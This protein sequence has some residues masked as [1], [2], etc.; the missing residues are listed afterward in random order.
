MNT[1]P[2]V[3]L[4]AGTVFSAGNVRADMAKD[5]PVTFLAQGALPAKHPP[6]RSSKT[7]QATEKDYYIF[8][9]PERSRE[10]IE[11]IRAEMPKGRF[12]APPNDWKNLGRTRKIL[13]DGGSLRVLALGDSIVNDT[14][15][16]GWVG[17]LSDAY[18]R[19]NIQATVYV[20]GGGGC[21]HYREEG[22][23]Q[24]N[25]LPR[26]PDL[27]FIGGISQKDIAGIRDVVRQLRAGLPEVEI[28]L[29]TGTFG[30]VDPRDAAALANAPCSGSGNYGEELRKLAQEERCA[31]LDL[32]TPWAEYIKS[33]KLH[34]HLFYRDPV[35]A[36][37]YGEQILSKIMLTFWTAG[38][39]ASTPVSPPYHEVSYPG[40]TS[41]GEL[42]LGATYTV[43]IPPG[44]AKLRGVIV[45]S[46]VAAKARA[47]EARPRPTIS[48]GR[49]WP[50]NGT[51]PC[52]GLPTTRTKATAARSG[53]I[54]GT[55]PTSASSKRFATWENNP[56]IR[57]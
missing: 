30:T 22:R 38:G 56:A 18:P 27:V 51:A 4:V 12:T 50:R 43:W 28:L 24:K 31:Y 7:N 14:M 3:L 20:R 34:P 1:L 13:T 26:R 36:N 41:V 8:R 17:N 29:G 53:A 25:I 54:P 46:T 16:S 33:S 10:Q 52:S 57:N 44:V 47:K 45:L 37:E 35:H 19:A 15:R 23:I 21:Q 6:D 9:T 32:T 5:S 2:L 39:T 49:P 48:S 11:R 55:D 40:S 42:S